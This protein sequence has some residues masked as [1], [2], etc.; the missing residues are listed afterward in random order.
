MREV[1]MAERMKRMKRKEPQR[2]VV[3]T[4]PLWRRQQEQGPA[5]EEFSLKKFE[6]SMLVIGIEVSWRRV[7]QSALGVNK[8]STFK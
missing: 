2:P 8:D 6:N 4:D 1:G 3:E 5:M 7:R